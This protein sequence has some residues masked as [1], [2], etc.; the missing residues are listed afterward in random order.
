MGL[1]PRLLAAA[2]SLLWLLPRAA[3]AEPPSAD[4][5]L[6]YYYM[7]DEN[8]K[9]GRRLT[10]QDMT[11]F[12]NRARCECNQKVIAEIQLKKGSTQI[13]QVQLQTFVGLRCD[14]AQAVFNPQLR[15]CLRLSVGFPNAFADRESFAI[16]P[17]WF[18]GGVALGADGKV[19]NQDFP[20]AQPDGS[21]YA[22]QGASGIWMCAENGM[23]AQC[24]QD[25]FF[26]TDTHNSNIPMDKTAAGLAY[27]FQPPVAPPSEFKIIP[28]DRAVEVSWDLE[29]YGD[30]EGFRILCAHADG[31]PVAGKGASR[32]DPTAENIGDIYFTKDS[33]CPDGPFGESSGGGTGGS[34][35][36]SGGGGTGTG[37]GGA[38]PASGIASLDYDY[39]CSGHLPK[40]TTRARIDGLVNG[41]TF[42]FLVVA[43]DL[44]GNPV[45]ASG[46]LEAAPE[47]TNDLWDQCQLPEF[48]GVCG[49]RGFC[50]CSTGNGGW[51]DGPEFGW[52]ALGLA[53]L[54][55]RRRRSRR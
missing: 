48:D 11:Q 41:E 39:I 53:A 32:R 7:T 27:D 45:A 15:Q 16:D 50:H 37:T 22:G 19:A 5:F 29:S 52:L 3:R 34:G 31:T 10:F 28:G 18:A 35:S 42:H 6:I 25:E 38:L 9:K 24:Q 14:E 47:A 44:F 20:D 30:I 13:D 8:G 43:Y 36:T 4:Q 26:I 21:C 12:V 33:L 17:V 49:E 1:R 46:V 55:R 51:G 2:A 23:Q 40:T 54:G